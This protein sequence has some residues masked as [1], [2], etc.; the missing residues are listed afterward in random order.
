MRGGVRVF[1][2][3]AFNVSA[4]LEVT[5]W[6]DLEEGDVFS[7]VLSVKFSVFWKFMTPQRGKILAHYK[8]NME[9]QVHP[10]KLQNY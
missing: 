6:Q 8:C 9:I 10:N 4:G 7:L 1:A 5:K 2:V 3:V